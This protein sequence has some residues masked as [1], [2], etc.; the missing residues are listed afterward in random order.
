MINTFEK[1]IL[2]QESVFYVGVIEDNKDPLKQ[3][4][5]RVRI[6]GIDTPDK[7][8]LPTDTL[9]FARSINS[10]GL[11]SQIGLQR[12]YR[13]GSFVLVHL[14]NNDR[15]QP[16]IFGSLE[17]EYKVDGDTFKDPDSQYPIEGESDY[18]E[19]NTEEYILKS[20]GV[21]VKLKE[22]DL[23]IKVGEENTLTF[24]A[25]NLEI[26]T[27][28]LKVENEQ[29]ELI[30]LLSDLIE[31]ISTEIRIGNMGA[32]CEMEPSS[33]QKYMDLKTKLDSFKV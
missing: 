14:L 8:V 3:G 22:E 29:G 31:A 32:P 16:I 33:K 6:L 17:G 5:Y 7:E 26:A 23:E 1:N 24:G 27:K 18:G 30:S 21:E 2:K 28:K 4:R 12:F 19:Y 25:E 11:I 9:P 15:M 20:K 10:V 13:Q